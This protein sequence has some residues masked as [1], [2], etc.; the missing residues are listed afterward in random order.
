MTKS[1][2]NK[3]HSSSSE[4]SHFVIIGEV[5]K[6]TNSQ[7]N[8]PKI[9]IENIKDLLE[10]IRSG[11]KVFLFTFMTGCGHCDNAKPAWKELSVIKK[12]GVTIAMLNQELLDE[13][14]LLNILQLDHID[15]KDEEKRKEKEK[16]KEEVLKMR[17]ELLELTGPAP[18]GFPNFKV[19]SGTSVKEYEGNRDVE[20]FKK[21]IDEKSGREKVESVKYEQVGWVRGGASLRGGGKRTRKSGKKFG[22]TFSKGKKGGKWSRKYKKSINC[23]R[24]KGFSQKQYCK[25]GRK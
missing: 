9:T 23:K 15:E 17:K 2:S 11:Q 24:P 20:S 3:S 14:G 16:Q 21:W 25:Y 8:S 10:N 6:I 22:S 7:L 12:D 1:S 5:N 4:G 19:I 13:S 18:T